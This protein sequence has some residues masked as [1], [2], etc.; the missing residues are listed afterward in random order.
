[1]DHE[2]GPIVLEHFVN[3]RN[4]GEIPGAS[5]VGQIK[6][7]VC[8]DLTKLFLRI[9]GGRIVDARFKTFGCGASI[10]SASLLTTLV[11]GKTV[12]E[13]AALSAAQIAAALGGLPETKA[14]SAVLAEDVLRAALA[15]WRARGSGVPPAAACAG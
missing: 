8:G 6:N 9:E 7:D 11:R 1:M 3:P 4:V 15:D 5:A 10:A 14:H 12:E 13:A 2:Y